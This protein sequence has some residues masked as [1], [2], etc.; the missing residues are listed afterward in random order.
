MHEFN[1]SVVILNSGTFFFDIA[2]TSAQFEVIQVLLKNI[3]NDFFIQYV[4]ILKKNVYTRSHL[5]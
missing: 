4:S 5:I 1:I 2:T 3:F